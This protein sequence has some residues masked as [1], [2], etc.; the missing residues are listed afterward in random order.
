MSYQHVGQNGV[1]DVARAKRRMGR[2]IPLFM[3]HLPFKGLT[4]PSVGGL[5][6]KE[7]LRFA[8]TL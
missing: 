2:P 3:L 1:D 7:A 6:A 5:Q 4:P 8:P